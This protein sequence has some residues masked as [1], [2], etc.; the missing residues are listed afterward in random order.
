MKIVFLFC[1]IFFVVFTNALAQKINGTVKDVKGSILKYA[2]IT[3]KEN[4]YGASTNDNGNYSFYCAPGTY[5]VVCSHIGYA[6]STKTVTI[7]NAEVKLDFVLDIQQLQNEA[8]V[9]KSNKEDYAYTVIRNA[10]KKRNYYESQVNQFKCQLYTKDVIQFTSVPDKF[11]GK[12]ITKEDKKDMGVDS[13]GVGIAYLSESTSEV[14]VMKPNKSKVVVK[15]SRVSGS[16][17]FGFTIPTYINLNKNNV[18]VF[19]SKLNPRGFVSPIADRALYYYKFKYL[20]SFDEDGYEINVIKVTPKRPNEPLFE[21]TIYIAE[22]KWFLHS[23]QLM[24][25][26]KSQLELLDTLSI[27]IMNSKIKDDI[28]RTKKQTITLKAKQFGFGFVG[29]FTNVYTSYNIDSLFLKS[30]FDKTVMKYEKGS[31]KKTVAYWDS[32]RPISLSE[33]EAKDYI[34]KDSIFK[35]R[36]TVIS[37]RA[38]DSLR[39]ALNKITLNKLFISGLSRSFNTKKNRYT[40]SMDGLISNSEYNNAEG[41]VLNGSF[42]LQGFSKKLKSIVTLQPNI[43]Y[44][45]SNQHFNP[46][47]FIDFRQSKIVDETIRSNNNL[48]FGFG[49]TV[50]QINGAEA[51]LP[52][53]NTLS[54]L[55]YGNNLLKNY[56]KK[57]AGI[58]YTSKQP[59]IYEY[60]INAMYE[61][62]YALVNT[63]NFVFK[64]S[65]TAKLKPN[66]ISG[67]RNISFP[68]HKAF[69]LSMQISFQPGQKFIEYPN[70]KVAVGSKY[71][72][73][74]LQYTKGI[75]GLLNSII[76]FDKWKIGIKDDLNLKMIGVLSYNINAGGFLSRKNVFI[77]DYQHFNGNQF[78]LA[79]DYLNSFQLAN[80]YD[81]S[82]VANFYTSAHVEYHLNGLLTN[83][84]PFLN[85][86]KW[87]I[88][89]GA[90][91]FY[92]N[93][94]NNYL[95]GFIGLE[96]IFK[97]FRIDAIVGYANGKNAVTGIRIGRGGILSG[98][99]SGRPQK[100]K[101]KF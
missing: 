54:T 49:K 87:N 86:L 5:T 52:I 93:N 33:Q 48:R 15:S 8:V 35:N 69:L 13:S 11:F 91:S 64:K 83:K 101:L 90:N 88:V 99:N 36:D 100:V 10:I 76:D 43:R 4:N 44:G 97:A 60:T 25:N 39:K 21:G 62:R 57:F 6:K 27:D 72:T 70:Y 14:M 98:G 2:S 17:Q 34:V 84:I 18:T 45:F 79:A 55:L 24:L 31:N 42:G 26:K 81:N 7:S 63:T 29:N 96:N 66:D 82:T 47:L 80:Y 38:N 65:D 89:T 73:F 68:N 53:Y 58:Q 46:N 67:S 12:K 56:E 61:D 92:V 37:K 59:K 71:P 74:S 50:S 3:I 95:E 30:V 19:S 40:F 85:K 22:D 78:L 20:G 28:W 9:I 94:T 1:L 77:Q 23:A 32:I 41:L 51:I 75:K 16:N